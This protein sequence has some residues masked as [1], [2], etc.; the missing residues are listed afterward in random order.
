MTND[1]TSNDKIHMNLPQF[2]I[3]KPVTTVMIFSGLVLLGLISWQRLPQELFPPVTYPQLTVSTS[4]QNAAP[5][6]IET[7]V[8]KPLEEVVGTVSGLRRISSISR[9]GLSLITLEFSWGTNMDFASLNVREKID[10]IKEMLPREAEEPLIVKLNPFEQPVM[11]LSVTWSKSG[12]SENSQFQQAELLRLSKKYIKDRLDKVSGVA[13]SRVSGGLEREILAELDQGRLFASGISILDVVEALRRANLNY[14]AGSFKGDFYEYLIRTMGEFKEVSDINEVPVSLDEFRDYTK[15]SAPPEEEKKP[16]R[17]IFLSEVG[18]VK[19]TYKEI[20]NYSRYNGQNNVS[21][22]VYKQSGANTVEVASGSKKAIERLKEELPKGILLKVIYDQSSFIQ[23]AIKGVRDAAILGGCLAFL[24]LLFFLQSYRVSTIIVISIPVSIIIVFALMYM[25]GLSLNMI[26]LGGLALGVGMLVDGA[27]VVIE[28]IFRHTK[29]TGEA[30]SAAIKG[31]NE[32]A[33]AI[34]SSVLTTVVVF[35]PMIF[36]VGIVGQL[37]KELAFTVTYS[38]LASLAVALTLVPLMCVKYGRPSRADTKGAAVEGLIARVEESY[39]RLLKKFLDK[40]KRGLAAVFLIFLFS[41]LFFFFLDKEFLPRIDEGQFT[42]KIDM[43]AG[44]LL[45]V[46]DESAGKIEKLLLGNEAVE[47]VMVNAGSSKSEKIGESLGSHQAEIM[48]NLV[49]KEKRK[50]KTDKFISQ[51]K[52][53]VERLDLRANNIE[54]IVRGSILQTSSGERAPIIIEI[55]GESLKTL[56]LLAKEAQKKIEPLAGVYGIKN[57]LEETSPETK[58]SIIKDKAWLYNLSV[59]DI[60]RVVQTAVRGY[61][62]T[63]FKQEGEEIDIRVRLNPEDRKDLANL[64]RL[65]IHSPLEIDIPLT[66]VAVL[67]QGKGPTAIKRLDRERVVLISANFAG[68]KFSRVIGEIDKRLK[69]LKAPPAYSVR[70]SGENEAMKESFASLRF[71]LILS[72]VLIYMIMAAQFESFWQPFII[73]FSVPLALIGVVLVLFLTGTP[74][75]VTVLFGIIILGGIVVDNGIVLI[76]YVNLLVREQKRPVYDA[77]VEAGRV[78][79]RPILMTSLTTV[80]G[81]VPLAF[82]LG[83]DSG[84]Q[85]PMAITVIGG[86]TV[87]TFLTLLVI[88]AIYLMTNDKICLSRN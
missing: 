54:Y 86:L 59:A 55:K 72:C 24:V 81:L 3:K 14:P 37:F 64:N 71:A 48:V 49:K 20:T 35:V 43:P 28:S 30:P 60:A 17:L 34:T 58:I 13:Y 74:V 2:S 73:M 25:Q 42:V 38:L 41:L 82:G 63:S 84:L 10:L 77:L 23:G 1:K 5:E 70:I 36:V 27:I 16:K 4:Y 56:D 57:T 31:T 22:S 12:S 7:L 26:S 50:I 15:I 83:D 85:A 87:S 65:I 52:E 21:I 67:S 78:R 76:D 75:N 8:T 80:L 51:F 45:E 32:V 40:R 6:E 19:D 88:P 9:E 47:D 79:L 46:T 11:I 69:T 18:G 44:T 33:A 39:T 68:P 53:E 62:P 61:V 29:E 66:K